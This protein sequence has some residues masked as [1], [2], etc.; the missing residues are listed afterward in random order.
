MTLKC[1]FF[2]KQLQLQCNFCV[3]NKTS[4]SDLKYNLIYR[5]K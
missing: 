2:A 1:T 3:V 5:L 4:V